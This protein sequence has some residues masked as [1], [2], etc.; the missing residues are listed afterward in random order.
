MLFRS[1]MSTQNANN[2]S[3]T[4]GTL[5]GTNISGSTNTLTN[6]GNSSLTNSS[7]TINGTNVSLGGSTT[8]TAAAPFALTI[9]AGLSGGSYN[10]SSA[11]TIANTGV[12]SNVAGTGISV[13]GATGNV[14][15]TNS[16]PMVYPSAGIPNSTGT[17]WGT[18]YS[19][20]GTGT[21][22]PLATGAS[23]STP[24]FT[25]YA[26]FSSQATNPTYAAGTLWYAADNDALT[27]YNG[28][29]GND[30]HLG[31]EVQLRCYNNTGSTIAMG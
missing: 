17:A 8:I 13:S 30:L 3:I 19:T 20:S 16:Q 2:V 27:F 25:D 6:I 1:T 4:G 29:T 23:I 7:I 28:A 21:V 22:V 9:G 24:T 11:V 10:G 15:I 26:T 12:L 31:Q 5:T 14:T 18:S